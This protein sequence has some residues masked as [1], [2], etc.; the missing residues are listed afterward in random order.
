MKEGTFAE[1]FKLLLDGGQI[2]DESL[3]LTKEIATE[4]EEVFEIEINENNGN[5]LITHLAVSLERL[6]TKQELHD[7]PPLAIEEIRGY[8]EEFNFITE[9]MAIVGEKIGAKIPEAEI[10]FLTA[11]LCAITRKEEVGWSTE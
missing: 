7:I 9:L 10:A 8:Q 1:R 5:M 2:S 3:H 4:I 11:H 6:I